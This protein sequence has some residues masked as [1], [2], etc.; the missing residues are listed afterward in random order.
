[1]FPNPGRFQRMALSAA[2]VAAVALFY[3]HTIYKTPLV[4]C[5][6]YGVPEQIPLAGS[7]ELPAPPGYTLE[8]T[9]SYDVEGLV[10]SAR[11][12]SSGREAELSP[13]DLALAWGPLTTQA[14]LDA[15]SYSQSGRWY[16]Y[17]WKDS[18][19]L[20]VSPEEIVTHSANT[21]ILVPPGRED[22]LKTLLLVR[23]G[24]TVRLSG[25]LVQVSGSD[26]YRWTSSRTRT[27]SGAGSCELLYLTS[28]SF[29]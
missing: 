6:P 13:V 10:V 26:G 24:H 15:I 9:D 2:A 5:G 27:D 7:L 4:E 3:R 22:L 19:A 12:Y 20:P 8:A 14:A 29:R 11:S 1:M 16:H 18:Q 28:L 25:Y 21:H 23:R 17:E